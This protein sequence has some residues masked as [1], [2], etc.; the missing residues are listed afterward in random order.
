MDIQYPRW[1]KKL[2]EQAL[3][4]RRVV[5]LSGPRQCGKTTLAKQV[6][7]GDATYRT[8]DNKNVRDSAALD[9]QGFLKHKTRLLIIDEV[10]RVPEL[11]SAI[12]MIV[13]EDLRPGQF[14]LTGST[15]IQ[16][17]P[18]VQESLAGRIA[19]IRLRPLSQGEFTSKK[20]NFLDYAFNQSFDYS[21]DSYDRDSIIEIAFRGGFPE[22]AK[23]QE[24][25]R[26]KWHRDYIEAILDRDLYDMVH[27]QRRDAMQDLVENMA[28][29]SSKLMDISAICSGLSIRRPTVESYINALQALY[30]VESVRPWIKTDYDRVGRQSKLFFGDTGLMSSILN[31]SEDQ[32]RLDPDRVGKLIETFVFNE[33]SAQIDANNGSYSLYH[34]RDRANREIDFLIERADKAILGLEVKAGV[35]VNNKDFQH[36]Q[37]FKD[38]LAKEKTFIGIVLYS[39]DFILPFGPNLWAIPYGKLWPDQ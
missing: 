24:N 20:P 25:D 16:L 21:C 3:K 15:N 27:I 22:A 19:K 29:W 31:W 23:H 32:V 39:G 13:D 36:L 10:Q 5:L 17:L 37:W 8:L 7:S 9:P 4:T 30:I 26:K 11:L 14:L 12:K 34:Y 33:I 18:T 1:Q 6:Q 38:N 28:S 2:A 35:S